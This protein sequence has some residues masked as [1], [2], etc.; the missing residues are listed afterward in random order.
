[1]SEICAVARVHRDVEV[2]DLDLEYEDTTYSVTEV[3]PGLFISDMYHAQDRKEISS[4]NIL[5]IVNITDDVPTPFEDVEYL[6]VPIKDNIS[7]KIS[8]FFEQTFDFIDD[9][10]K[11]GG[12]LVHCGHGI[13][14]APTIVAAYLMKKYKL[15]YEQALESIRI[16]RHGIDPNFSFMIALFNLSKE[17][18]SE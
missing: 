5:S 14:R 9:A 6:R 15:G 11:K 12:V 1:M 3:L 10:R 2:I 8:T 13:S 17:I 7:V 16:K 18:F 4:R